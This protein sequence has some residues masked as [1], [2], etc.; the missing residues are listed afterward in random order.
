MN[1]KEGINIKIFLNGGGDGIQTVEARK[2]FNEIID[3][4]KPLLYVPLAMESDMY[5]G[6]YEWINGE[7]RDVDLP[8]IEMVRSARELANKNLY[9]YCALFFGGGNTFKLLNDLKQSGAFTKIK[10]YIENDGVTF[11][12]SAGA[13]IFGESLEA[14]CL[15]DTNDVGLTDTLGFDVLNGISLLCHYTNRTPENHA[16]NKAYLTE[17]SKKMKIVALPE[18]NT[19]FINGNDIKVIGSRPYYYFENGYITEKQCGKFI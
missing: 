3:H 18:E 7:M 1:C 12:G 16:E 17:L 15:D 13:I 10:E 5:D 2:K 11:G 19:I 6:C 9:D 4:T 14:C 8:A